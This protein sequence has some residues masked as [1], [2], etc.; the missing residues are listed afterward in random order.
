MILSNVTV[1]LLGMV[2]TAVV[3]HLD[4][5]H[6]LGAVAVGAT[7]FNFL[8]T[9]LNFL[10][11]GTTG[12]AAQ[13]LGQSDHDEIRT[14]LMQVTG[15]ALV[16]GA[17]L[18]ALQWPIGTA[19]M[20]LIN[21]APDV[22]TEAR[23]YF[24]IR[25]W[26]APAALTNFAL[27]GWFIGMH[28]GRA[29]LIMMIITN[30]IN[31]ALD[32]YFVVGLGMTADGVALAS[33]I[34]EYSGV[35][36]G[37]L[38]VAGILRDHP[39]QWLRGHVIDATKMRRLF[40]V[41]ANLLVRTMALMFSFGFLTAMSARQG[42]LILAANAI[43][44]NLQYVM[45]YALDGLANAAEALVGRAVGSG[46]PAHLRRAISLPMRWSAVIAAGLSAL[47]LIGGWWLIRLLTDLDDVRAAALIY[48]P[49]LIVSP[50]VS[51][52]SFVYD[53]VYVGA[54]LAAEMRNTM[55][56]STF[57]VFLPAYFLLEPL[58]GNH[59]LWLAFLLFM[60]ARGLTMHWL[61]PRRL[62]HP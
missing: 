41:N 35:T 42:T 50:I 53:G 33:V 58:L 45:S 52:W 49:W 38:M 61:L 14:I 36:V 6:Y 51:V 60:A 55:L 7:I 40:A 62:P 26:S 29:P 44:L 57:L 2:D 54:T 48:L 43:L 1:P 24:D 15:I 4:S 27:V 8:Y 9:G 3:G 59:G 31:I 18:L 37:F 20:A 23:T 39:G 46:R 30:V 17:C 28:N 25:I 12:L 32:F 22:A 13:A 10:R 56:A 21:P 19:A 11:M 5:P 34:A 47:Y 16:L